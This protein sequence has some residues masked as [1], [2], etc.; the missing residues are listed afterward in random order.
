[1]TNV[2]AYGTLQFPQVVHAVT[3]RHFDTCPGRLEGYARYRLTT[4]D[5]PGVIPESGAI[6]EGAILL[7]VDSHSL[8]RINDYEGRLYRFIELPVV[9]PNGCVID[10]GVYVI[11]H[12]Y[13][14]RI[15]KQTWSS[16]YFQEYCLGAYL[17]RNRLR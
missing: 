13:R 6:T 3:G 5:Y 8:R 16:A 14:R 7:D 1:M 10:A 17:S 2:F 9:L 4:V 11:A 15:I 12:R